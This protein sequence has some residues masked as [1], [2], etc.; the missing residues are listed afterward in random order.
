[1]R[2]TLIRGFCAG[3]VCLAFA[4]G[5]SAEELEA[6]L[7]KVV[8]RAEVNGKTAPDQETMRCLTPDDVKNRE[9]TFSPNSRT[10]NSSCDTIEHDATPQRLKWRLQCKGQIDMDVAGEFVFDASEHYTATITTRASMLGNEIQRSQ[11][12]IEA[13]RVGAC[14]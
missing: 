3:V 14:Q 8:T 13:Q 4:G 11:A 10:T 9:V 12:S 1:M 6:G 5:A 7:W 2:A